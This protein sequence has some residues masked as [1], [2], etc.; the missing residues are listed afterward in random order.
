M[1]ICSDKDCSR[2]AKARGLCH[3]HY[4]LAYRHKT[5]PEKDRY[6]R[7][8][9]PADVRWEKFIDRTLPNGCW[10]WTGTTNRSGYGLFTVV[11][12]RS[13]VLAHRHSYAKYKADVPEGM[14]VCHSCDNR[15]CVN[16]EHLWIGSIADNNRD[17]RAKG[18]NIPP[19]YRQ[20]EHHT[21]AKLS[22][23]DVSR[24]REF[25]SS[26]RLAAIAEQFG[27]SYQQVSRIRRMERWSNTGGQF[28]QVV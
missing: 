13:P 17:C 26:I 9:I 18:R 2:R 23:S 5:L 12:G 19:P 15:N 20:G 21:Q 8:P 3:R 28:D 10:E 7:D 4:L 22:A 27:I 25:P 14:L 6:R 1:K 16:P 24:I 11:K